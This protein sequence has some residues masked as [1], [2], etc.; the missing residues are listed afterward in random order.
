M[1]AGAPIRVLV[2]DD[3]EDARFLIGILLGEEPDIEVVA[4][5][6]DAPAALAAASEAAPDVVLMDAR[7]PAVDGFELTPQ[8]LALRPAVRVV[9]LTSLVDEVIRERA[10]AAGAVA[11]ASKGDLDSLGPLVRDALLAPG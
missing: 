6:A 7:M 10:L 9:L 8:V 5:V 3:S 1:A 11:C 4:S 2:V